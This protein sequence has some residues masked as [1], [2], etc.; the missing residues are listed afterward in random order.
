MFVE[1]GDSKELSLLEYLDCMIYW[2]LFFE[3]ILQTCIMYG[4]I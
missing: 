2:D 4:S 3:E 1:K